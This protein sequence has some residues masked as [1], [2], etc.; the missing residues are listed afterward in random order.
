MSTWVKKLN[1]VPG[2]VI[3]QENFLIKAHEVQVLLQAEQIIQMAE[4]EGRRIIQE[5]QE[6]FSLEKQRGW[7]EGMEEAQREMTQSMTKL[8]SDRMTFLRQAEHELVELV[9]ASIRKIIYDY[10]DQKRAVGVIKNALNVLRHQKELRLSVSNQMIETVRGRLNE[11]LAL[12]PAVSYIDLVA[13]PR[14]ALD[15]CVLES[16]IGRVEAKIEPQLNALRKAFEHQFSLYHN[17][18]LA[19][20]SKQ[21][22]KNPEESPA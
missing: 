6:H 10:D 15:E 7:Q 9:M 22:Q 18:V 13:D 12:Y 21:V 2:C 11:L 3:G 4:E 17:S 19:Q 1:T 8:S 20:E 5:A 16:K 14:L